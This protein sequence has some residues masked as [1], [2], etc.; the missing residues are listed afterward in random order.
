MKSKPG[1]F[2]NYKLCVHFLLT[3][4]NECAEGTHHCEQICDNTIGSYKCSCQ[5][6]NYLNKDRYTCQQGETV[7][8]YNLCVMC[9]F[10]FVKYGKY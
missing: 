7:L 10:M 5:P 2:F 6:G 3:D 1:Q 8:N 4:I 9:F